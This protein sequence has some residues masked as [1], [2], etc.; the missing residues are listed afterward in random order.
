MAIAGCGYES[1]DGG[2]VHGAWA[3]MQLFVEKRLKSPG[4]AE[5]RFGGYRDVQPLG[6]GRY[7]V[8]SYV[9]AQN[10]FGV[11]LRTPFEGVIKHVGV[12]G[13]ELEYLDIGGERWGS[14]E[15]SLPWRPR[16]DKETTEHE[17]E[18]YE[19]GQKY[20]EGSY[21]NGD[22][23]GLWTNWNAEGSIDFEYSGIYK[24]DKKIA[25]HPDDPNQ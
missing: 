14:P 6:D 21:K 8:V 25:P 22:L 7:K 4:S 15:R 16:R 20:S 13:W 10:G 12:E 5:F 24:A 1:P 3:Y 11:S 2:G 18:W 17:V 9:D 19:N 23:E